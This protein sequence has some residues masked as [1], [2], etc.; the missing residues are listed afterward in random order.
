MKSIR[1]IPL[2]L[3]LS[4]IKLSG[5][6]YSLTGTVKDADNLPLAFANVAVYNSDKSLQNGVITMNDGNFSIEN[7]A[8]ATYTISISFMGY[9]THEESVNMNQSVQL[10]EIVLKEDAINLQAVKV[11]G[12]RK[13]IKNDNGRTTLNVEGSMLASIPSVSMIMSFV[14]GVTVHGETV[15]VIGKGLPLIFINGREVK[16]QSQ[17]EALQP[18]R[19][20]SITVDRNPSAK[21][22]ARYRSVVH[23]VT[24]ETKKQELSAQLV[25]G[26]A[27]GKLYNNSEQININHS[28]GKWTNFL[29]YKYKNER[30]KE[31]VE[32][33]QNVL[34]GNI[35]QKNSYDADMIQNLHLH[36]LTL[37]SNLKI[38]NNHSLDLQYLLNK[39]NGKFDI[40]GTETL[41]GQN[42]AHYNVLRNGSKKGDKHTLNLNYRWLLD[43]ISQFNIFADY[44]HIKNKDNELVNNIEQSNSTIDNYAL[45]NN[46]T[47]DTY[48]LRA[49]YD[50]RLLGS[51]DFK[52]G[53]KFSEIRNNS[54]SVIDKQ[55]QNQKVDNRSSLTEH[56]LALYAT[57]G[58][59]FNRLSAEAGLRVE[60]NE[61]NYLKNGQSVFG[62]PRILTNLFPS[63]SLSYRT[64][65]NSQL[66]L[67]Y[68]SKINRPV[69]SDIDPSVNYL[70]SVL[71]QQGNPELKPET[72]HTIE[73]GATFWDKLSLS[74]GYSIYKN[75]ITYLIE[76]DRDNPDLLFNH[77]VNLDKATSLDFNAA[78]NFVLGRWRSN[79]IGNVSLPFLE[80]PYQ[81]STKTNNI[82]RYQFVTTNTYIVSSNIFLMGNFV[83]QSRY[84]YLN[85]QMSPT[86]NLVLAA[87][88]I[89]L[90]GKMTL[91]VFGN[92]LLKRSQPNT[93]SEWG[94]VNTGQNL[95]PDTRQLGVIV[96]FNL[97]SFKSKFTQSESNSDVL[98]RFEKE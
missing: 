90:K 36:N 19:I 28:T 73:L 68:A 7:L 56:T 29:S 49:E 66:N 72:S 6:T 14:P 25:H 67:N 89:L 43:S 63:L 18:E 30:E 15:E 64:T 55:T 53:I 32:V 4:I 27:I 3:L 84:S 48:A 96:K 1:L 57:L 20:K 34:N 60:R 13:L 65:D 26:S 12:Y 82:P 46:S 70:S 81:G 93:Y 92:D 35:S 78:Y 17:I 86:Y 58:R 54:F 37:G 23:I 95:R 79:L 21:Y 47:F 75:A 5:Q 38:N 94:N 71:Y 42:N 22:D 24:S 74:A 59:Q 87:N 31:G 50:K 16:D 62:K 88:F 51:F 83:T 44:A 61:S 39:N 2:I 8:P 98:K 77:T 41:S 10:P 9:I 40:D 76:P 52:G 80:Y 69:F 45:N 85:N 33:F 91:T 97:N 11:M